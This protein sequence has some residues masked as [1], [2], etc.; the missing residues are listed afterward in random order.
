MARPSDIKASAPDGARL[1]RYTT[2]IVNVGAGAFELHAQRAST[3]DT[4]MAVAQRIFDDAGGFRDVS[5]TAVAFGQSCR[6]S[7]ERATRFWPTVHN[8]GL[9][10]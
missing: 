6:I 9:S 8:L 2:T 3:S 10:A 1:L 4:E 7:C 5:T